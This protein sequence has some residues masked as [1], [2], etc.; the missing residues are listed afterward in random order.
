MS[1]FPKITLVIINVC[2]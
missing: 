2:D 1:L